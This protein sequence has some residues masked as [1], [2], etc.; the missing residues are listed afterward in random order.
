MYTELDNTANAAGLDK[1][2]P[3]DQRRTVCRSLYLTRT[4]HP[5]QATAS[6][7]YADPSYPISATS[8]WPSR[9]RGCDRPTT[10]GK[11][12]QAADEFDLVACR[13]RAAGRA[14]VA[15]AAGLD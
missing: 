14:Q 5:L 6:P 1:L 13:G 12:R 8:L 15:E 7:C 10:V 3:R 11:P 4:L 9:H 2:T